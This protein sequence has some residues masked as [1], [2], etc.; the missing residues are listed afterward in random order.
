MQRSKTRT[1]LQRRCTLLRPIYSFLQM[2]NYNPRTSRLMELQTVVLSNRHTT[3]IIIAENTQNT[4]L[5]SNTPCHISA[6]VLSVVNPRSSTLTPRD[7]LCKFRRGALLPASHSEDRIS[8]GLLFIIPLAP[9]FS[10]ENSGAASEVS[11]L[12]FLEASG[13]KVPTDIKD[14]KNPAKW[15]P[16][17]G[18]TPS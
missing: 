4:N 18:N 14:P 3:V 9:E 8:P 12:C 2:Q 7:S 15:R 5:R 16:N 13:E 10:R 17:S 6:S 1:L 11:R